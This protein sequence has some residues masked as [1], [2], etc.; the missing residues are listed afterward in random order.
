MLYDLSGERTGKRGKPRIHG[1]RISLKSI[2]LEK[3]EGSDHYIGCCEVTT[4]LWKGKHAYAYVTT[5]DPDNSSSFRL[6]LSTVPT[7]GIC[8]DGSKHAD[9]KSGVTMNAACSLW[10]RTQSAGI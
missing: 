4:N 5:T 1:E 10:V 9:K 2:P 7:D 6:F 8:V 3:T